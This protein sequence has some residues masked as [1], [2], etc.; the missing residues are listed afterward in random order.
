MLFYRLQARNRTAAPRLPVEFLPDGPTTDV[1][2]IAWRIERDSGGRVSAA[3][4]ELSDV[5]LAMPTTSDDALMH[6]A[7]WVHS[8][9][10]RLGLTDAERAA[11]ERAWWTPVFNLT[12]RDRVRADNDG[13]APDVQWETM[14][15]AFTPRSRAVQ[16]ET[17]VYFMTEDEIDT[18]VRLDVEPPARAVR[19]AFMVLHHIR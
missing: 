4:L 12:P 15:R 3:R 16:E 10:E 13:D 11:F 6:A 7:S 18:V 17:L 5:P 14:P 9:L 1:P 2:R 19:R 8:E